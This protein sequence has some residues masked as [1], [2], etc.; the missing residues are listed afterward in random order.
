MTVG[1]SKQARDW[2]NTLRRESGGYPAE[3]LRH[4]NIL[5][6]DV[7]RAERISDDLGEENTKLRVERDK[8]HKQLLEHA[9]VCGESAYPISDRIQSELIP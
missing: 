1:L 2:L 4:I 7:L 5:E 9:E 8:L 3:V 6:E